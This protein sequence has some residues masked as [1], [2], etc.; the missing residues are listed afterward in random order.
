MHKVVIS[1]F[2][3]LKGWGGGGQ[4]KFPLFKRGGGRKRFDPVLM[5]G[6]GGVT[7]FGLAIF[8]FCNQPL[9]VI[10]DQSPRAQLIHLEIEHSVQ[11]PR[12]NLA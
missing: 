2:Y 8:P 5:R 12:R 9:P 10:N 11:N 7:S 1:Y 4:N 3:Q 6:E